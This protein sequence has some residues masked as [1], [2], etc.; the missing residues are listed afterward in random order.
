M[1]KIFAEEITESNCIYKY[2]YDA[3][4]NCIYKGYNMNIQAADNDTG[5]RITRYDYDVDG[6]CTNKRIKTNS[7]TERE[8]GW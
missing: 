3:D 7:W 6:Q 4:G 1:A 5:W 2:D 8:E